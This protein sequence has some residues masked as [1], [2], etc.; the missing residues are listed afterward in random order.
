MPKS[1]LKPKKPETIR[2][3]KQMVRAGMDAVNLEGSFANAVADAYRTMARLDK[4]RVAA[5]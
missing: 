2:V 4:S 5:R 3:T 1:K